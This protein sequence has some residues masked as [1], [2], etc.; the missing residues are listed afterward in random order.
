ME[1]DTT[2]AVERA[3]LRAPDDRSH[4]MFRYAPPPD[5]VPLVQRFWIP[6][7]SVPPGQ[8]S[9]QRV[10]Q[11]PVGLVVVSPDYARFYGVVTGLSET[12]LAGD[13]WAVGVMLTPAAGSLVS[14]VDMST[15]TDRHVDIGELLGDPGREL[16]D[17]V[18]TAMGPDP[19]APAA[20]AVAVQAFADLLRPSLPVDAEGELVDRVVGLVE[21][22]PDLVRV[23]QLCAAT[24]LGERALQRLVARRLGLT[25]K[26]LVQRRRLHEAAE[27]LRA[28]D[29]SLAETA[30]L[31]GY[32]DQAHFTRDWA[33]VVGTP[34]G[35]FAA[36]HRRPG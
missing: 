5:L 24:G 25:P 19:R 34:P 6:V 30:T 35:R 29:G 12:V 8:E 10:L 16:A 28:G 20:H 7:W 36:E 22:R 32:A 13:G 18:R 27:R 21:S 33:A 17:R 23:A 3:H 11:Y 1:P 4:T 26:W 31:L 15:L 2:D 9:V 14:G